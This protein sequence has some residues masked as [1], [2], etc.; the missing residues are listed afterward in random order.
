MFELTAALAR[1]NELAKE[2]GN[3]RTY[4]EIQIVAVSE[5]LIE[6]YNGIVHSDGSQCWLD[7]DAHL[8]KGV[9]ESYK[10]RLMRIYEEKNNETD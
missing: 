6:S 8:P 5:K 1:Y 4:S 9:D 7:R 3:G 2:T 10:E